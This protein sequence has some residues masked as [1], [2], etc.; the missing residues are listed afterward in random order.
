M[1]KIKLTPQQTIDFEKL[2]EMETP[3]WVTKEIY[4]TLLDEWDTYKFD[5]ITFRN[6]VMDIFLVA[7]HDMQDNP[8]WKFVSF[9]TK[10]SILFERYKKGLIVSSPATGQ[11]PK[12]VTPSNIE[13]ASRHA[14]RQWGDNE[15]SEWLA[16]GAFNLIF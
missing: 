1:A 11:D 14:G 10:P 2:V 4:D 6:Y 7:P 5:K 13:S 12:T 16:Y 3:D 15:G 9:R 8:K